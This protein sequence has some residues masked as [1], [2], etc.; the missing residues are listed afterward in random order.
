M[1]FLDRAAGMVFG[2]MVRTGESTSRRMEPN[3]IVMSH[4]TAREMM[5]E[6]RG[7]NIFRRAMTKVEPDRIYGVRIAY[8]DSMGHGE[9]MVAEAAGDVQ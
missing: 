1:S 8:D 6:D 4:H 3:L 2:T 7:G 9:M 5:Q